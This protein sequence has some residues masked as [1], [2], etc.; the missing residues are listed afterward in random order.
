M[1][2]LNWTRELFTWSSGQ[3]WSLKMLPYFE[4]QHF[5]KCNTQ[6][7]KLRNAG[8]SSYLV[9]FIFNEFYK[10]RKITK[11]CAKLCEHALIYT[12][13]VITPAFQNPKEFVVHYNVHVLH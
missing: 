9:L 11:V 6:L 4:I 7:E 10:S 13:V 2:I 1:M 5:W 3:I 8:N 12:V